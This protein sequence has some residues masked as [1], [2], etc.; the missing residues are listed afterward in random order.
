MGVTAWWE[1]FP[2]GAGLRSELIKPATLDDPGT[3]KEDMVLVV[4]ALDDL[5][6]VN[7]DEEFFGEDVKSFPMRDFFDVVCAPFDRSAST[8]V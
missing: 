6:L 4:D 3:I 7:D 5:P 2:D 8:Y 1:F